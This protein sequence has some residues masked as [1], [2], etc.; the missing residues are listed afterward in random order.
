[1]YYVLCSMYYNLRSIFL[2]RY[3]IF[4]LL[5]LPGAYVGAQTGGN[6]TFAFLNL[7]NSARVGAMGGNFL[8]IKD[9]DPTLA[10]YNPSLIS[11]G[12]H[13]HLALSFVDYYAD[14]N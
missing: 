4:L 5:L 6:S 13:N 11:P 3:S 9:N 14:I 1:M 8:A 7:V 10:V 2:V 12:I